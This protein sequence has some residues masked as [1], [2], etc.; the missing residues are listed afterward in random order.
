MATIVTRVGKG[1]ELT[2]AEMDANFE[3]LN[4]ALI[5]GSGVTETALNI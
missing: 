5:N 4:A 3:N 2:I 1:T